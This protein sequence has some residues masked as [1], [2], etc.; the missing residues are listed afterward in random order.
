MAPRPSDEYDF[1]T[2]NYRFDEEL[3][4]PGAGP[5]YTPYEP[6]HY[7]S[8][9]RLY[10]AHKDDWENRWPTERLRTVAPFSYQTHILTVIL[11]TAH[12]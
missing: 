3:A 9:H 5:R 7:D 12:T 1:D 2:G 8:M 10:F 4:S 6:P 11:Y